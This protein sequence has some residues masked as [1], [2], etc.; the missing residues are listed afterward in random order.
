MR[1]LAV[2][3]KGDKEVFSFVNGV[4]NR[5]PRE[6]DRTTWNIAQMGTRF[7]REQAGLSGIQNFTGRLLGPNGITA[8]KLGKYTYGITMPLEG[9]YL[10]RM[11]HHKVTLTPANKSAE[12]MK[13]IPWARSKGI[14]AGA[15]WVD[16]HP[17]IEA[18]WR[19]LL[20]WLDGEVER[21]AD[22]I[23]GG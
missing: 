13:I 7:L 9:I 21:T 11:R 23:V 20:S 1:A 22:K 6:G 18:G 17:F 15:I 19:N 14:T 8:E 4:K 16:K 12:Q 2:L 3:V 5:V 10:D